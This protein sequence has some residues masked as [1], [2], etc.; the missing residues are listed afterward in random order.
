MT[1]LPKA[2][3]IIKKS[4]ISKENQTEFIQE[5]IILRDLDHPN[6]VKLFEIYEDTKNYYIITEFCEGGEL[7][8]WIK[9]NKFISE[10]K[11]KILFRQIVSAINYCH[12]HNV[13]HRDIKPENI[14]FVKQGS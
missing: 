5:L 1:K 12:S 7:F 2:L 10:E 13:V 4:R 3:K 6:I 14:M 8:S 11:I 9:A